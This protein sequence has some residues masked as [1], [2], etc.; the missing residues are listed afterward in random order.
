[1]SIGLVV[2]GVSSTVILMIL[3]VYT[4]YLDGI[5]SINL[6]VLIPMGIGLIIGGFLFLKM[7]NFSFHKFYTQT[8]Y[9]IIGFV[10]GSVFILYPPL[11]CNLIGI[12]SIIFCGLSFIAAYYLEK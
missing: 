7:I 8:Y 2:P 5:A 3:G 1:M 11:D 10:V 4:I 9:S 12:I 6:S